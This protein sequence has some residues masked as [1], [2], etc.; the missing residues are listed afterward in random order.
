MWVSSVMRFVY[1]DQIVRNHG[2]IREPWSMMKRR[3]LS[4]F[5]W[6]LALVAVAMVLIAAILIPAIMWIVVSD[7]ELGAKFGVGALA[8]LALIAVII[9]ISVVQ[10]LA[11]DFVTVVMYVRN[12]GVI[13]AWRT[14]IPII[15]AN[16]GSMV[17]Y[18]LI[19]I[20][21]WIGMGMLAFG[22]ALVLLIPFALPGGFLFG[23]GYALY[24]TAGRE[25]S[26]PLM[27]YAGIAGLVLALAYYYALFCVLQPGYV[28]RRAYSLVVFGM[29]DP[30][31]ATIGL[32]PSPATDEGGLESV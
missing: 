10:T 14:V 2:A 27:V 4:F 16:V 31:L 3:G 32:P 6:Q 26:V 22:A 28:L 7:A 9:V 15:R 13:A 18:L 12:I 17:V 1:T 11:N 25:W 20:L 24:T 21:F 19:L 30:S 29:A 5:L 8:G 23:I